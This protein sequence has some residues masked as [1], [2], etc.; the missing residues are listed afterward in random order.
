MHD[1]AV[2]GGGPAGLA[3]TVYALRK[4]LDVVL[5]GGELGGKTALTFSLPEAQPAP[6]IRAHEQ[7]A[8]FRRQVGYLGHA[9]RSA[10]AVALEED[11]AGFSVALSDGTSLSAGRLVVATGVRPRPLGVRGEGQ[12]FGKALGSN[13]LSYSQLLRDR[14]V[15]IVGDSDRALESALEC[16]RQAEIVYLILEPHAEYA[17][18]HLQRAE[19]RANLE[20]YNGYHVVSFQGDEFARSVELCRGDRGCTDHPHTRIEADAFFVEREPEPNSSLVAALV[21]RTPRGAIRIDAANA[22]SNPRI[23]AAGDVTDVG[24]EQVLVA[25]G[26]GARAGLAAYR[27][28]VLREV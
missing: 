22:T 16:A 26:E 10:R 23:F 20:I 1:L 17:R 12:F 7:V 25:L 21:H 11:A 14:R 3:A 13:S 9:V 4:G 15:V 5:V 2:I 27:S 28:L 6:A 8:E 18:G 24:V 19:Q